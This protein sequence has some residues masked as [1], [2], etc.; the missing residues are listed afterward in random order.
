MNVRLRVAQRLLVGQPCR[1]RLHGAR[2]AGRRCDHAAGLG[3]RVDGRQR[4]EL[5]GAGRRGPPPIFGAPRRP[6]IFP[7]RPTAPVTRTR[8]RSRCPTNALDKYYVD[9]GPGD[10]EL[11]GSGNGDLAGG[12]GDDSL[13]VE[14]G[15][16]HTLL[17]GPGED[18]LTG[19]RRLTC[20]LAVP[21]AT[22]STEGAGTT[23]SWARTTERA[24]CAALTRSRRVTAAPTPSTAA[25]TAG[26]AHDLRSSVRDASGDLVSVEDVVGE[27]LRPGREA[28]G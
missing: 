10:D 21:A 22:R 11:F 5:S 7:S 24:M 25:T 13:T 2:R 6:T 12:D 18:T 28:A 20:S 17:G 15:S 9:G 3:L 19:G 16:M 23:G 26:C 8:S 27:L 1:G 4:G 14:S